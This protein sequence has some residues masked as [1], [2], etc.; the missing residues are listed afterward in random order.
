MGN[1]CASAIRMLQGVEFHHQCARSVTAL[2]QAW[3]GF[4]AHR[5]DFNRIQAQALLDDAR[6]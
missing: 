1:R 5:H 2:Y 4:N 3:V 6:V